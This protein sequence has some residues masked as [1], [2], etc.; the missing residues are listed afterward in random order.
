MIDFVIPDVK[1]SNTRAEISPHSVSTPTRDTTGL[2][3]HEQERF[4]NFFKGLGDPVENEMFRPAAAKTRAKTEVVQA[5]T[6]VRTRTPQF[7]HGQN[8]QLL[9]YLLI[10]SIRV[11]LFSKIARRVS[12]RRH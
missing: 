7:V 3:V 10:S 2:S 12:P 1:E 5:G 6:E 4:W 11:I 9:L 8:N